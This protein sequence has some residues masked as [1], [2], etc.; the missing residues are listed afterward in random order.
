[1]SEE[2]SASESE[3]IRT[4]FLERIAH[5]LRGPVGVTSGAL[6]EI[7]HLLG[8]KAEELRP[9]LRMAHRGLRRILRSADRLDRTAHLETKEASW[10]TTPSDLHRAIQQ[11]IRETQ[12]VESRERVTVEYEPNQAPCMA[13]IDAPWVRAAL[14]EIVSNAI[15]F[16][17]AKVV[18]DTRQTETEVHIVISDDGPGFSGPIPPRFERSEKH[19]GLGLSLPIVQAV[20]EGHGGRLAFLDRSR[21][22]PGQTGTGVTVTFPRSLASAAL[23]S[24]AT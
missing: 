8:P 10:E 22:T 5:D 16:A 20:V 7:E 2:Q 12:L 19:R 23:A 11:V 3:Y 17:R 6:D 18:I 15:R 4:T 14:S 13:N 21:E 24:G 1:V 9:L